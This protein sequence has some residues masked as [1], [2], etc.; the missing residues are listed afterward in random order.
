M[1]V[2]AVLALLL[3][4]AAS[5]GA[6]ETRVPEP[7]FFVMGGGTLELVRRDTG[8]RARVRYIQADG[9]YDFV[10]FMEIQRILRSKGGGQQRELSPRFV[11]LL[12]HVY[13][14]VGQPLVVMSGYRTP[15]YNEGIRRR[16]GK[17]ASGSLHTEGLAADLAIPRPQLL[18]L[19]MHLR[20]LECCGAGYYERQGFLHLDVGTPRFWEAA[21]SRTDE[22]LNGGNARVFARTDFDR[23]VSGE[24]LLVRFHGV[25]E[26]PIRVERTAQLVPQGGAA[27]AAVALEDLDGA[28]GNGCLEVDAATRLLVKGVPRTARGRVVFTTCAPRAGRTPDTVE[29]NPVAVR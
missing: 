2:G 23:Y 22:D 14:R 13:E 20:G 8:E 10:A 6:G 7:R 25:T 29:T 9:R 27:A 19:W 12:G 1:S 4:V 16:G 21:T 3:G 28:P 24:M 11:E 5:A 26:P 18:P 17:A 15:Q